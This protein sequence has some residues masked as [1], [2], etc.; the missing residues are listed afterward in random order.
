MTEPL[1]YRST[2]SARHAARIAE[3]IATGLAPDGGLYVPEVLP[4]RDAAAFD[5]HGS[6]ADT[7]QTLL[8][9]FF[10]AT[11]LLAELPA[12]CREAFD[13]PVPLRPL[14]YL[15]GA[16]VLEL[17]HGPVPHSRTSAHVSSPRAFAACGAMAMPR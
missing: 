6:L 17:F 14:A 13:F 8:A 7:A 10:R 9:P 12:I 2:R 1:H 15:D 11:P 16:S 4:P 3:V 5:P